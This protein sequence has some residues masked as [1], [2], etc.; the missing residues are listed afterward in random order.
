MVF[1]WISHGIVAD[2]GVEEVAENE[3]GVGRAME[4]VLLESLEGRAVGSL[5]M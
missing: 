3:N 5:Q 1:E 2:P 4:Q